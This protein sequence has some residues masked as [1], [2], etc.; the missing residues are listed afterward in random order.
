MVDVFKTNILK[1]IFF[2]IEILEGMYHQE[3]PPSFL[4]A[5][6]LPEFFLLFPHLLLVFGE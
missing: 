5:S 4:M 2:Y 3:L 1:I 6:S